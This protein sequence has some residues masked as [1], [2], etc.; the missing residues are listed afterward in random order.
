[1]DVKSTF[2]D[3]PRLKR[4]VRFVE[5][6]LKNVNEGKEGR[7]D[8]ERYLTVYNLSLFVINWYNKFKEFN[9]PLLKE[10]N[11]QH[12]LI[13]SHF[14]KAQYEK[15]CDVLTQWYTVLNERVSNSLDDEDASEIFAAT[16]DL[17]FYTSEFKKNYF[18]AITNR[19]SEKIKNLTFISN[20]HLKNDASDE[21]DKVVAHREVIIKEIDSK[22]LLYNVTIISPTELHP[23][24]KTNEVMSS[25]QMIM[26][27]CYSNKVILWGVGYD[28]MKN[29][30]S[31][32]CLHL[33][34]DSEFNIMQVDAIMTDRNVSIFYYQM[35]S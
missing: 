8:S 13:G 18:S 29:P 3:I 9:Y 5:E 15:S 17:L 34:F 22:I 28:K 14:N 4:A 35:K 16:I 30:F 2:L 6:R 33:H 32:Y 23:I 21:S 31:N 19:V 10:E 1:M 27:G 24:W 20:V 26:E 12:N 7:G 25:K 11:L